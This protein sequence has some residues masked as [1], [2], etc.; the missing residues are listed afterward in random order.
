QPATWG[1]YFTRD[2]NYK[3]ALGVGEIDNLYRPWTSISFAVEKWLL[4]SG[5]GVAGGGWDFH[6]VNRVLFA[7]CC[8]LAARVG[9]LWLKSGKAGLVA[10]LL[11][12]VHPVHT[13]VAASIVGRAD[14]L[15]LIGILGALVV[16]LGGEPSYRR[17]AAVT[18]T[19][20]LALGAKEQ[21]LLLPAIL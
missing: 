9:E 1:T 11:F 19:L 14:L 13:D 7:I 5:G 17:T 4:G 2:Y 8:G 18:G 12:A 16:H 3:F 15:C 20:I 10:G 6:R 21:G